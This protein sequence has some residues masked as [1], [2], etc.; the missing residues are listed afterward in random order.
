MADTKTPDMQELGATGLKRFSGYVYEEFLPDLAGPRGVQIY[1]EMSSNDATIGAVLFAIQMLCRRVDWRT[2]PASTQ[3]QDEEAA[4]FVQSCMEDM[5]HTWLD[6]VAEIMSMLVFGHDVQELVYKRRIGNEED[7]NMQSKFA[8]GKIGWRKIA[9][10]SQDTLVRW[11][12]DEN[13]GIQGVEQMAPP[14]YRLVTIP[15]EKMLLFRTSQAKNNPE[16]RSM[17]RNAYRA[18]YLKKNIEN[19]E[20]IGIERDLAGLP[21]ALV[22]PEILSTNATMA[23]KNILQSIKTIVTNIRRDEQ[24]GII[25]PKSYDSNGKD[26]YELKLLST[27]GQRQ[28][29]TD[30]TIQRYD[31]RIAMTAM[32]DFLLLGHNQVGSFALASSKTNLFSVAIGGFLDIICDVFN[33]HAIPRLFK[34]NNFKVKEFPKIVHGDMESV[35]LDELGKYVQALAGAGMPLFPNEELQ[36]YLM[37]V[38][39]M[40]EP[41]DGELPQPPTVAAPSRAAQGV[42][43]AANAQGKQVEN[44]A[45]KNKSVP[46]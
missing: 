42:Q 17:L 28:F 43:A 3:P 9:T 21:V 16:G 25:F 30:K 34:F 19:I 10:R 41:V 14:H 31:Q 12:F 2:D 22:P 11:I 38:A 24:E 27:A 36:K 4:D 32:A 40:P 44:A 20:G 7:P 45:G 1:K 5:S 46:N 39:K 6:M 13:G 37:K 33:R 35:D 8:D 26:M 15:I 18:W 23:E 29:D